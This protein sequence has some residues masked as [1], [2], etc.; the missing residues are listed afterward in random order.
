M[1]KRIKD[2]K[3]GCVHGKL[4]AQERGSEAQ[5]RNE[6]FL[7]GMLKIKITTQESINIRLVAYEMPLQTGQSRGCCVDLLGYDENKTPWIIELKKESSS[8]NIDKVVEQ[9]DS[10]TEMFNQ[11]RDN[12]EK[13][14]RERYHWKEFKFSQGTGKIILAGRT[15][16][17][18]RKLR[19]YRELGIYCCL[20]SG[21]K[22][23]VKEDEVALLA[24]NKGKGIVNLKIQNR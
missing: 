5:L 6:L 19:N 9:V 10:Y 7:I 11:T 12:I 22:D 18:N 8:E 20:F 1:A 24:I 4:S 17:R 16:F 23:V 21:I 15:F 2:F 13:E 14:I 3:I